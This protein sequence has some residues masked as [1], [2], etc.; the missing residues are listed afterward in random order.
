MKI[1]VIGASG[2]TG[3]IVVAQLVKAGHDVRAMVRNAKAASGP[4]AA[5]VEIA[6]LELTGSGERAAQS[7]SGLD[8]VINAAAARDSDGAQ[9]R[10]VDRDGV[11][12]AIDAAKAAGVTRWIQISMWG[13]DDPDR[14]PPMLRETADA[15]RAAD[16]HLAASGMVWTV[17]RPPWL[18]NAPASDRIVV[19]AQVE[20]GSLPREDLAA[21]AV[22]CLD[23]DS[24]HDRVF[25][26]TG[27]GEHSVRKA[28]AGL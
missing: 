25:E 1:G 11:K 17:V 26:V 28:L 7:M 13:S 22:A 8:A 10:A 3:G 14:L 15:K 4:P 2:A 18:T 19:G 21:V 20:E 16:D 27:G 24:T 6:T 9:A 23:L 5:D 12:S